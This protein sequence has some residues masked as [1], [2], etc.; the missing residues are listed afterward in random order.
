MYSTL[1][2][3]QTTIK[4]KRGKNY[5]VSTTGCKSKK[6]NF[7]VK[8]TFAPNATFPATGSVGGAATTSCKK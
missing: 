8:F 6:H 2:E 5:L 1:V 4:A 3:L 7:G